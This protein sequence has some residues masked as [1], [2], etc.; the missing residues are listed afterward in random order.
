MPPSRHRLRAPAASAMAMPSPVLKEVPGEMGFRLSAPGPRCRASI[1]PL[2]A[3]PPVAS[4]TASAAIVSRRPSAVRSSTACEAP[5]RSNS[6]R[7]RR[8]RSECRRPRPRGA[9]EFAQDG[10]AAADG[11]DARRPG[12]QVVDRPLEGDRRGRTAR[13]WSRVP[14]RPGGAHRLRSMR[15]PEIASRSSAKLASTRSGAAMRM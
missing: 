2:P 14:R 3:K 7:R 11:L 1:S 4:T 13:R 9:L 6:S 5:L 8:T 10:G 12:A 15:P